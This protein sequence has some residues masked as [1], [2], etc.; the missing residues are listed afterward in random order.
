MA[1]GTAGRARRCQNRA[2]SGGEGAPAR[3]SSPWG[4]AGSQSWV[5]SQ[6]CQIQPQDGGKGCQRW[7]H[8]NLDQQSEGKVLE[9][10]QSNAKHLHRSISG[11]L[12]RFARLAPS[13]SFVFVA[14]VW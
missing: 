10:G 12:V 2:S 11:S 5:W 13:I 6:S 4:F 1:P 7:D 8:A 14:E 9:L 3:A